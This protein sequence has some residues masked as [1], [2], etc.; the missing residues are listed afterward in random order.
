MIVCFYFA[1]CDLVYKKNYLYT[2]LNN[3]N[4]LKYSIRTYRNDLY[5][6][7]LHTHRSFM[8]YTRTCRDANSQYNAHF[9]MLPFELLK[10]EGKTQIWA[11]LLRLNLFLWSFFYFVQLASHWDSSPRKGDYRLSKEVLGGRVRIPDWMQKCWIT[12]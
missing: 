7:K 5:T 10:F 4:L 9:F 11:F 12:A 6:L 3:L 8:C 1:N 2:I